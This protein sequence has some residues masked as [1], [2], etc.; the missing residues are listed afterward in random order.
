MWTLTETEHEAGDPEVLSRS[1][2]LLSYGDHWCDSRQ[3]PYKIVR[4]YHI[5]LTLSYI[6]Q[7]SITLTTEQFPIPLS[8][9]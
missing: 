4:H 8:P 7:C 5:S 1:A 3:S 2:E 6:H 9:V